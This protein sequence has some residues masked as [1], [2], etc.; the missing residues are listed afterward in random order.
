MKKCPKS[1]TQDDPA[2]TKF[3]KA[4]IKNVEWQ[5][6]LPK[7]LSLIFKKPELRPPVYDEMVGDMGNIINKVVAPY[8]SQSIMELH[9][10]NL[11]DECWF[12]TTK[13]NSEGLLDR[14]RTRS[15]YFSIYKAAISNY[16]CSLVQKHVF[17]EKRSG[18]KPPPK[19]KR[20]ETSEHCTRSVNVSL[21]DPDANLQVAEI[22]SPDNSPALRELLEEVKDRLNYLERGVLDQLLSPNDAALCYAR[23]DAEIGREIGEPLRIRI[24]QEH[25]ARGLG[26]TLE[27]FRQHHESIK[28]KC[29]YM[30][31]QKDA[32]TDSRH[33]A[34]MATLLHFFGIQI[35]RSVDDITRRRTLM[36]AARHQ[37]DRLKENEGIKEAL[38]ICEIPMPEVR[39]ERYGCFGVMFQKHHRTCVN[40]GLNEACEQKAANFGLGEI[41][42]SH[43][44]LGSRHN[45]V[46]VIKPSRRVTGCLTDEKEEEILAFLEENFKPVVTG[47]QPIGYRHREKVS[48]GANEQ[49]IFQIDKLTPFRLKF[50][51]P[52]DELRE[53]LRPESTDK[54]GRRSWYL[55]DE[56]SAEDAIDLIR[57]HAKITFTK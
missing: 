13:M 35:P 17:T 2:N 27:D 22:E 40:C 53:H 21:D 51:N 47:G 48:E 41:T 8:I 45:R 6:T 11:V 25:L 49:L 50:V 43:K 24:R 33:A 16:V 3:M 52:A 14:C 39:N 18:Q 26:M 34:A 38:E 29:L 5:L 44:L 10:D 19:D 46:P 7:R 20:H 30:K 1:S 56:I 23:E 12:K 31:N 32:D 15:E 4:S 28:A 55:P 36:I 54:G 57:T 42:I 37:Y 9:F